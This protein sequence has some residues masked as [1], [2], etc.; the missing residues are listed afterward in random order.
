GRVVTASL[1][2]LAP[3]AAGVALSAAPA[4]SPVPAPRRAEGDLAFDVRDAS[5]GQPIPCKLTFVGVKGTPR[6]AFTHNDIGRIEGD[7]TIAAYDRVM[8]ALGAGTVGVPHGT[9]DV[10]VSRGIEL[11]IAI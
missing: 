6:P 7:G 9:Y 5:T 8:S 1:F 11:D 2:V 4:G 3:V 10:Y